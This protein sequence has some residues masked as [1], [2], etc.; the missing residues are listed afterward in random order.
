M[1]KV[2]QEFVD[3]LQMPSRT[4]NMTLCDFTGKTWE[5]EWLGDEPGRYG[6]RSAGWTRFVLEHFLEEGDVCVFDLPDPQH[7]HILVH[8]FPVVELVEISPNGWQSH[9]S[10]AADIPNSNEV[11]KRPL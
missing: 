3:A 1:Q 7:F 5:V 4:M 9:Y 6:F 11:L 10:L 8:I 2:P